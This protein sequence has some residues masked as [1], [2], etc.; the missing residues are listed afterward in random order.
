M[1]QTKLLLYVSLLFY[2]P[3]SS[4]HF[5]EVNS[6]VPTRLKDPN[7]IAAL[8]S[9][10]NNYLVKNGS[11]HNRMWDL[12]KILVKRLQKSGIDTVLFYQSGCVGCE[13][14]PTRDELGKLSKSCRCAE[15]ELVVYL[16]WQDKGKTLSKKLDCCRNQPVALRKPDVINFYF[17]NKAHFLA[18]EKFFKDFE[19]Y[20][21][22]HTGH[23]R[24]LPSTSIHDDVTHV[25]FYLGKKTVK[26][27]VRGE[28]FTAIGSPKYLR[29]TWKRK[30]WEWAK[31]IERSVASK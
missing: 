3:L 8:D 12:H 2:L 27:Q 7:Y 23:E 13:D 6:S 26:F 19:A 22:S 9:I 10:T 4:F 20:N 30:Q 18:G 17:Q 21:R 11:T 25:S 15:D 29:Y 5:V 1:T 14:L 31:L 28:E 16:F 24:F